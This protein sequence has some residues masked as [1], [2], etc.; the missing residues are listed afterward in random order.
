GTPPAP[1]GCRG[2]STSV[3]PADAAALHCG[4]ESSRVDQQRGRGQAL[5]VAQGR[6]VSADLHARVL[7]VAPARLA[8]VRRLNWYGSH[9]SGSIPL[10]SSVMTLALSA[11]VIA[12]L[13]IS[14]TAAVK[15]RTSS[16]S[17]R[18]ALAR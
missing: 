9:V 4:H 8:P 13:R 1:R 14:S 6:Q 3:L 7:P 2:R 18:N 17:H 15:P 12:A 5:R 10:M 11:G 16:S